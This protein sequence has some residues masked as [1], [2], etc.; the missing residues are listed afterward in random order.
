[1]AE[2]LDNVIFTGWIGGDEI[3]WLRANAAVG[4]QPYADCA[5]QGLADKLFEYLSAGIPVVS[6]LKGENEELISRYQCGFTYQAGDSYDCLDKISCLVDNAQLRREMGV[7]GRCL[8][9]EK[10]DQNIVLGG[11]VNHLESVSLGYELKKGC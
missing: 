5:P 4:L 11:L 9:Q 10:F 3:N 6:S 7:H 8:F 2:E 1:M